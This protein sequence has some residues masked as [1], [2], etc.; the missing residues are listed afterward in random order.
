MRHLV[1][2]WRVS[3]CERDDQAA[4]ALTLERLSRLSWQE[5]RGA[6]RHG[7]GTEKIARDA[8]KAPVPPGITDD[9]QFLALRFSGKKAMVGFRGGEVFHVVWLD[10]RFRLYDH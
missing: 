2:G 4:F 10:P 7:M 5:I 8:L 1:D 9:V 6:P 3:D